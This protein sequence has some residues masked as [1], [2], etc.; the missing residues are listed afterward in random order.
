MLRVIA[1]IIG[2]SKSKRCNNVKNI[3]VYNLLKRLKLFDAMPPFPLL[4]ILKFTSNIHNAIDLIIKN[5]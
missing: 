5:S 3:Q 1:I 2:I 4:S